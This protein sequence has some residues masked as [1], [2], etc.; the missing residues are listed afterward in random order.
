MWALRRDFPFMGKR[1]LRVLLL[2]GGVEPGE[3]TIGR[4][5]AKGVRLGRIRPCAFCCGRVKVKQPRR[6]HGHARRLSK[7]KRPQQPGELVQVDHLS[8]SRDSR[9]LK[10]FK[11]V[12]P[13][14]KQMVVQVFSRATARNV[15]RFLETVLAQ[16]PFPLFSAQVDGGSEFRADFE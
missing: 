6:F 11:A 10:E 5:L 8:A 4:I 3:S 2:R 1:K 15:K 9:Q 16:L 12:S 7:G 14:G 13:I